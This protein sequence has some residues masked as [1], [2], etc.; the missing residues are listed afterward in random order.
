[1]SVFGLGLWS[2]CVVVRFSCGAWGVVVL[3]CK[4]VGWFL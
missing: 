3:V 2:L 1:M 4:L